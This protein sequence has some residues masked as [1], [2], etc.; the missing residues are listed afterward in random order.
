[1]KIVRPSRLGMAIL[2][3]VALHLWPAAIAPAAGLPQPPIAAKIDHEDTR[4]GQ[5]VHDDYYWMRDK[6]DPKV[7]DYLNAENAYT[8][9]VTGSLKPFQDAL[10][11]EMLGHINQTDLSVPVR[12]GEY[13]Y[14]SRTEEGKQYP[15]YCRKSG[16]LT[17]KEEVI[18][19]LNDLG[20][21]KKFVGLGK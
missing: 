4:W 6:S 15:M 9:S 7:I 5:T 17:G 10:Y 2:T 11:K 16:S 1:M 12:R 3:W 19:D 13:S 14:Y 8:D 20:K 18:L 21:G